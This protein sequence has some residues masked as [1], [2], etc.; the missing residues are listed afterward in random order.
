M[1]HTDEVR[2]ALKN[3]KIVIGWNSVESLLRKGGL[4]K[5]LLSKTV[6]SKLRDDILAYSKINNVSVEDFAGDAY[7]LGVLCKKPFG[8]SVLGIK[9]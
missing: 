5:V 6:P 9:E 8:V 4:K 2:A 7:E 1:S 3:D